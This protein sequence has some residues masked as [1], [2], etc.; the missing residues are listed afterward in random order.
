MVGCAGDG[1]PFSGGDLWL[2][3]KVGVAVGEAAPGLVGG[4]AV[5]CSVGEPAG[6]GLVEFLQLPD[7]GVE[8]VC[9]RGRVG[10][11]WT[12]RARSAGSVAAPASACHRLAAWRWA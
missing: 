8:G 6:A 11:L 9:Q 7:A 10:G 5:A 4:G 12:S 3:F 2:A 1:Q